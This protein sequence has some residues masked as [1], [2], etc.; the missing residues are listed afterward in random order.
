M[1]DSSNTVVSRLTGKTYE[2]S[3]STE[4]GTLLL[5]RFTSGS[6]DM[7]SFRDV[8]SL[9]RMAT[10]EH[11]LPT[12]KEPHR[13]LFLGKVNA[14][15]SSP[16]KVYEIL[17]RLLPDPVDGSLPRCEIMSCERSLNARII[18]SA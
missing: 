2:V 18:G 8:V 14:S 12:D 10:Y 17:V 6:E 11:P 16:K 1:P 7:V 4:A 5:T 3:W 15:Q 9:L 13:Y